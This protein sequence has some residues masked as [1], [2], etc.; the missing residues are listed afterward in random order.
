[1]DMFTETF[2]YT[3]EQIKQLMVW[4]TSGSLIIFFLFYLAGSYQRF[5]K[6]DVTLIDIFIGASFCLCLIT[7]VVV[8]F[9][10]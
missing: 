1:M 2:G 9:F 10:E 7:Y 5:I 4:M 6:D 8:Y 3:P